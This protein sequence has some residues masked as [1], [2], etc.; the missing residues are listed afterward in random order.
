[1]FSSRFP[2]FATTSTSIWISVRGDLYSSLGT[3]DQL[4]A[5]GIGTSHGYGS[6][7]SGTRASGVR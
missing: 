4:R 3:Y 7:L 6:A 2:P 5:I 1:M